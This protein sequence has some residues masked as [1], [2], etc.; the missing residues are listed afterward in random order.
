VAANLTVTGERKAMAE[1]VVRMNIGRTPEISP[2][3]ISRGIAYLRDR[4]RMSVRKAHRELQRILD[5]DEKK[6]SAI[7]RLITNEAYEGLCLHCPTPKNCRETE[8]CAIHGS[9]VSK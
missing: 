4:A 7:T 1:P 6:N 3:K 5:L 8:V 9:A 2:E